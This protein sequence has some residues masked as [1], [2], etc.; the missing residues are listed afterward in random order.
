[1]GLPVRQRRVLGRIECALRGSDP[2]LAALYSIFARLNRDEDIPRAEQL[3]HRFVVLASHVRGR[4]TNRTG[5]IVGRLI[6][7]QK[8]VLLFPLALALLITAVVFAVRA[9]GPACT[10]VTPLA[11]AASHPSKQCR[12]EPAIGLYGK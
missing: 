10:P 1:M 3:R 11:A 5:R 2:R 8:A 9:G 4:A 7:R 12:G 6:P